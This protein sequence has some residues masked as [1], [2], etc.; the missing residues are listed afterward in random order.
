MDN[1]LHL[2]LSASLNAGIWVIHVAPLMETMESRINWLVVAG[3]CLELGSDLVDE[4]LL[5]EPDGDSVLRPI[6]IICLQFSDA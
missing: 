2:A 1:D 6:G 3:R 4:L 5:V